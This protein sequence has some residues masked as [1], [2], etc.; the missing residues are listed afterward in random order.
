VGAQPVVARQWNSPQILI[1]QNQQQNGR[2]RHLTDQ[3]HCAANQLYPIEARSQK[4]VNNK[5]HCISDQSK[6]KT[7]ASG[8]LE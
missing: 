3:D 6:M 4:Q 2:K 1:T 7:I 8:H 5:A